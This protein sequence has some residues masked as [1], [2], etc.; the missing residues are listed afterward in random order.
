M[1][2]LGM[3]VLVRTVGL[4]LVSESAFWLGV[5]VGPKGEG[6]NLGVGLVAFGAVQVAG[7]GWA[8]LD[9]RSRGARTRPPRMAGP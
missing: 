4:V 9:G 8:L 7:F 6:A 2:L 5:A 3:R 1:M